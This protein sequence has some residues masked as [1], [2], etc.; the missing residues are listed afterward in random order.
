MMYT[1]QIKRIYEQPEDTDGTR[2]LVDRL[3]P[4][5]IS[6]EKAHLDRWAK[7]IAPSPELRKWYC[8]DAAL[9]DEFSKRYLAELDMN[10][11]GASFLSDCRVYLQQGNVTLVYA[12]KDTAHS[13]ALVLQHWL[14]QDLQLQGT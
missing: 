4:R 8:H 2:I 5:G 7:E 12:A 13:H 3:W 1:I 10:E 11:A 9:Y 6:K 14:L